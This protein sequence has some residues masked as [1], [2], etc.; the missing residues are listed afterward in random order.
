MASI[1]NQEQ[2][3]I[4]FTTDPTNAPNDRKP[5][6]TRPTFLVSSSKAAKEIMKTHEHLFLD[7]PQLR[8]VDKIFYHGND[9]GFSSYGDRWRYMK[10]ICVTH[11]LSNKM[12]KSFQSIREEEVA[13]GIKEIKSYGSS[14][15]NLSEVSSA[16]FNGF[17]CRMAL[18]RKCDGGYDQESG[19]DIYR[20][21]KELAEVMGTICVGD[22][23]PSLSWIDKLSGLHYR[24]AN[25]HR[26]FDAF[27]E[28]HEIQYEQR[29]DNCC[30]KDDEGKKC[31]RL[32]G[33]FA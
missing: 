18:G 16:L 2:Q 8:F 9:V 25:V 10:S 33:A 31:R 24:M 23:V 14:P 20:M 27:I 32:C 30:N 21:F 19:K 26:Q 12:V 4:A 13:R 7:R 15:L 11:L 22:Y 3:R 6:S 5:P 28:E 17:I 29:N 1:T